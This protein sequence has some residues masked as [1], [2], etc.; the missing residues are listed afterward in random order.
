MTMEAEF[1]LLTETQWL[2]QELMVK[3]V[4]KN[5]KHPTKKKER[6]GSDL[7]RKVEIELATSFERTY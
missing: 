5:N 4:K 3:M 7:I 2:N 6:M 1:Q